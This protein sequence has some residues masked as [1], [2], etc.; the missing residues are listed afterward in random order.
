MAVAGVVIAVIGLAVSVDAAQDAAEAREKQA[1][2]QAS[3]EATDRAIARRKAIRVQRIKKA[4]LEQSAVNTGVAE[5]SGEIAGVGGLS[6]DFAVTQGA[7]SSDKATSLRS[8]NNARDLGKAQ[9]KAAV[10]SSLQ[11]VGSSVFSASQVGKADL[12]VDQEIA[13]MFNEEGLF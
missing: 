2:N 9:V 10:G 1:A 4:Q 11:S 3:K 7:L 12:T 8:F 5:S 13:A 6:S